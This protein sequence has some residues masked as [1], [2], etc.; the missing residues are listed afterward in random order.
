MHKKIAIG[1]LIIILAL[2]NWTIAGKE[3][4]LAEGKTVYLE[5]A[6]VD[7]RSLMQGDHMAL[8]FS[9]ANEVYKFL[10]KTKEMASMAV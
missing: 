7:P 1:S 9:L 5:L 6:P 3:K 8:R 2:V 4:H 10:P